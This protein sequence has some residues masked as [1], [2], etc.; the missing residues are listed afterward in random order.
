MLSGGL[1]CY[2]FFP[3]SPNWGSFWKLAAAREKMGVLEERREGKRVIRE[4]RKGKMKKA[5]GVVSCNLLHAAENSSCFPHFLQMKGAC[6]SLLARM[7]WGLQP[8]SV[9]LQN[10]WM[11]S[12]PVSCPMERFSWSDN[13]GNRGVLSRWRFRVCMKKLRTPK[14]KVLVLSHV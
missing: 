7:G 12:S 14:V 5:P 4:R 11:N 6:P 8:S 13:F 3:Q 1:A 10:S 9:H 2:L